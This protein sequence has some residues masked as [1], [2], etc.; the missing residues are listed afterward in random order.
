MNGGKLHIDNSNFHFM[1]YAVLS[2]QGGANVTYDNMS[3][4]NYFSVSYH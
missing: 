2:E 1:T 4:E 3:S